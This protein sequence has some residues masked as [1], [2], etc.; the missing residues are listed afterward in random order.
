MELSWHCKAVT[1]AAMQQMPSGPIHSGS[2]PSSSLLPESS[3]PPTD[4]EDALPSAQNMGLSCTWVSLKHSNGSVLEKSNSLSSVV[5]I[6]T[7]VLES[8]DAP[9]PTVFASKS[10]KPK[11]S[12]AASDIQHEPTIID[13]NDIEDP[14]EECLNKSYPTADIKYFFTP[15]PRLSGQAKCHMRCNLCR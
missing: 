15:I 3:L 11:H 1:M 13:I 7:T 9:P 5:S 8:S 6:S 14:Q 4:I 2:V 12:Q 10:K